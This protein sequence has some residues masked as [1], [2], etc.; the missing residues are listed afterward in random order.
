MPKNHHLLAIEQSVKS[1]VD[2][3][4]TALYKMFQKPDLFNGHVKTWQARTE[5]QDSSTYEMLPDERK[6]VQQSVA[7]GLKVIREQQTELFDLTFQLNVTNALAKADVAVDGVTILKDAP[8]TYLLWLG[9]QLDNMHTEIKKLPTLDSAEKWEHDSEQNCYAT[10]P[11]EQART[12]KL[13]VPLVLHPATKEHPAQVKEITED[14]RTG[15]WKTIKYSTA[16]PADKRDAMLARVEKL[17]HAV[18]QA[19]ETANDIEVPKGLPSAGKAIY[20]F[21]FAK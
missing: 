4:I 11:S 14:V 1:K 15:T 7:D 3:K 21:V 9:H 12:K 10:K 19:K 13:Q 16:M 17:Q 20:D 8:V 5:N 18:K 2:E 6:N